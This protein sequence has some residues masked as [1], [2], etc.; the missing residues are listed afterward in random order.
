MS[1]TV[2]RSAVA[3]KHDMPFVRPLRA[4]ASN[5]SR[6]FC[7][8]ATSPRHPQTYPQIVNGGFI[9]VN[10]PALVDAGVLTPET[11]NEK[12]RGDPQTVRR[13]PMADSA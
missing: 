12:L 5:T 4:K 10:R 7:D 9:K 1:F 3:I 8:R 11:I 6:Q 2:Y 13:D